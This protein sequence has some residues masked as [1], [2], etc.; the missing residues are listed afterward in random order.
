VTNPCYKIQVGITF[1]HG[2][3]RLRCSQ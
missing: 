2:L 3:F 1:K